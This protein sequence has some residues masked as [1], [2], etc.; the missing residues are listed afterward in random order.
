[1]NGILPFYQPT[2]TLQ[3][4]VTI[5]TQNTAGAFTEKQ[6]NVAKEISYTQSMCFRQYASL[7]E[8]IPN[9][10]LL[11]WKFHCDGHRERLKSAITNWHYW[12]IL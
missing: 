1:M 7:F 3:N 9:R 11:N 10:F 2:M 4:N 12:P 6:H 8:F 5:I